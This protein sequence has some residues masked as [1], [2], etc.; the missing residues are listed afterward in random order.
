MDFS[1]RSYKTLL[2]SSSEKFNNS[3][4]PILND[5]GCRNVITVS[6]GVAA[7]QAMVEEA[8]DIVIINAPLPDEFGTKMALDISANNGVGIMLFVKAEHFP[9]TNS[10]VSGYGVLTISKPSSTA[11]VSQ[12][13]SILCA[14][15]ERL[16]RMEKKTATIEEKMEEIRLVNRAKWILIENLKMTE[17][18]VHRYI[19]KTAMDS[20]KTKREVAESII[21]TYK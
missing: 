18:E 11:I 14:T 16:R 4:L 3:V 13:L 19:E 6:S 21:K 9:E 2:V 15:R 1:E 7:R 5:A 12:S 10:R 17:P 8:Y 20:C